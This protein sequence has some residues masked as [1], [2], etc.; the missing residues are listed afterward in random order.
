VK[1][2]GDSG[3]GVLGA[4]GPTANLISN[5]TVTN[6]GRFGIEIKNST[7][8]GSD[9]GAGSV[10]VSG[11]IVARNVAATDL[12]DYA[13][14]LVMR[15]SPVV[16]NNADQ[17]SSAVVTGNTVSG[18]RLATVGSTG[19]GFGIVIEGINNTVKQ[20]I[21]TDNDIAIQV[22]GGNVAN[23]QSTDFFDRGDA[24]NGSALV[25]RNSLVGNSIGLRTVGTAATALLNGTCNW[26]GNVD[27][28]SGSGPGTGDIVAANITFNPWL[29]SN[30]L[31]GPCA[32]PAV[33][34]SAATAT[35]AENGGT[36]A[37]EVTLSEAAG[38]IIKVSYATSNG[39]AT[40]G[41]D[42]TAQ[43]GTL[44]FNPGVTSQT[45]N[46]PI[47]NNSLYEGNET[48]Q[49]TLSNPVYATL[50]ALDEIEVT[51][52]EDDAPPVVQ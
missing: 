6:N 22:Q 9:S 13:G 23:T 1:G 45:I 30:D 40:A 27:G 16:G 5:N 42:Y 38:Q 21:V 12:R 44:T 29:G 4:K 50:G 2:N 14:I 37:L 47:S 39:T 11:N 19:D 49:V 48:F 32:T 26:W 33:Q 43:S 3:I 34:F 7:G 17:P 8:N 31:N 25:N 28:P 36:I 15:R 10:V 46:V 18:Y 41:S 52:Q 20:N 51:I 24:A 35:V